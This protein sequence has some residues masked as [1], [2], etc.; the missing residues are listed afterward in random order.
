VLFSAAVHQVCALFAQA[1]LCTQR[2]GVRFAWHRGGYGGDEV[3]RHSVAYSFD[4][5]ADLEPAHAPSLREGV[6]S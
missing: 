1:S 6:A 3:L 5:F 4:A 2:S